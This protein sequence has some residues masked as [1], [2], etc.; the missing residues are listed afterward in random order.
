MAKKLQR[1][2]NDFIN[3]GKNRYTTENKYG[4]IT[5]EKITNKLW[6]VSNI[7]IEPKLRKRGYGE[8]LV[9]AAFN[10]MKENGATMVRLFAPQEE[11]DGFWHKMGFKD[12]NRRIRL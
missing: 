3:D 2:V 4:F 11:A 12:V 5:I 6:E 7:V 1:K 10:F 9:K 8:V